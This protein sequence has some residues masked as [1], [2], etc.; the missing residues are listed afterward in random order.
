[1]LLVNTFKEV[2]AQSRQSW[3]CLGLYSTKLLCARTYIRIAKKFYFLV[4]VKKICLHFCQYFFSVFLKRSSMS[5]VRLWYVTICSFCNRIASSSHRQNPGEEY[6]PQLNKQIL[7]WLII[8]VSQ[9]E[10]KVIVFAKPLRTNQGNKELHCPFTM[11]ANV[12][13]YLRS[14]LTEKIQLVSHWNAMLI[15]FVV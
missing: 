13:F 15:L 10:Q 7:S 9:V 12:A 4:S 1:M 5:R 2:R 8:V 3:L 14:S 6:V 11:T